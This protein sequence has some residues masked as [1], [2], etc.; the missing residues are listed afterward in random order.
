VFP[1]DIYNFTIILNLC[2]YLFVKKI[3]LKK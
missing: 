3:I 2:Q 1:Q